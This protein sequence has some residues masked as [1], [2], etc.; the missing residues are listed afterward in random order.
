MMVDFHLLIPL[1][2]F[3][4]KTNQKIYPNIIKPSLNQAPRKLGTRQLQNLTL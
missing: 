4:F 3:I 1:N 2:K